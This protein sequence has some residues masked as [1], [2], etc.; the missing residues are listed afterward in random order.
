MGGRIR[1]IEKFK[2]LIGNRTRGLPVCSIVP[3]PTTQPRAKLNHMEHHT[4]NKCWRFFYVMILLKFHEAFELKHVCRFSFQRKLSDPCLFVCA[5]LSNRNINACNL[6]FKFWRLQSFLL[7][8]TL[9]EFRKQI[10][11]SFGPL[12]A[13]GPHQYVHSWAPRDP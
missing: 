2:D 5:P 7:F 10:V 11:S 13:A 8:S 3:Q 12:I 1:S 6:H 9:F 4:Y